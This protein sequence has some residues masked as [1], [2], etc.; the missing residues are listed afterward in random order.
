LP[1]HCDGTEPPT[2]QL[3]G[4][5][6]GFSTQIVFDGVRVPVEQFATTATVGNFPTPRLGWSATAGGVVAGQIDGRDVSG[7]ATLVGSLSWLPMYERE[8]RPFVAV[9][10]SLGTSYVRAPGDDRMTHSWL[11][12]DARAGVTV[13]KTFADHFV[14]YVSARG[15]GGPVMWHRA[16]GDV[17]GGDRYH[18]TV[19]GGLIVR[20]PRSLDV[21]LEGMG[22]GERSAALG[23][24]LHL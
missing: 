19:G 15:F 4:A 1:G 5:V 16:G 21:A 2:W 14:P 13:G 20:L 24:T 22:L 17:S 11:A 9:T 8:T 10:G 18:Y 3:T 6:S 23:V 7:G 12:F